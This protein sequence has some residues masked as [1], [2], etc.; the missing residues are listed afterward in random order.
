LHLAASVSKTHK[1]YH[2]NSTLNHVDLACSI[3]L[4]IFDLE[5]LQLTSRLA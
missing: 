4:A 5:N 2:G 1:R 3:N